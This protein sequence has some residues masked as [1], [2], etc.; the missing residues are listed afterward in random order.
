MIILVGDS[1]RLKIIHPGWA[2]CIACPMWAIC[3]FGLCTKNMS[4]VI[5][6]SCP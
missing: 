1:I 5:V 4:V 3:P 6:N 2:L